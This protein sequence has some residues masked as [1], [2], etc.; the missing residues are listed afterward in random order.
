MFRP[1]LALAGAL[2]IA[3]PTAATPAAAGPIYLDVPPW[4]VWSAALPT[5]GTTCVAKYSGRSA[6]F[7]FSKVS[8]RP[9]LLFLYMAEEAAWRTPTVVFARVDDGAPWHAT[10]RANK[11]G[12]ALIA[13]ADDA[14]A[15][16]ELMETGATLSVV[17]V[18][19]AQTFG[20]SGVRD[21]LSA[22]ADCAQ[23]IG[24]PGV[25]AM[26]TPHV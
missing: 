17:T 20:L 7:A 22:L 19:G 21:A 4:H 2:A 15:L 5:G 13:P 12:T 25:G 18:R 11:A 3:A 14:A 6:A 26:N 10:A 23:A 9:G 1:L 16:I 24:S 8:D